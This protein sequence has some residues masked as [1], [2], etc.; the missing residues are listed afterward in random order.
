VVEPVET[1]AGG[2]PGS[3]A[4]TARATRPPAIGA[5]MSN[6]GPE[7]LG[8]LD[9]EQEQREPSSTTEGAAARG[10]YDPAEGSPGGTHPT[11]ESY[12]EEATRYDDPR[13]RRTE[14]TEE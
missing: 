7:Q 11:G 1:T 6:E 3:A 8:R 4:G 12:P 14:A 10:E 2:M 13:H 5:Q 9:D